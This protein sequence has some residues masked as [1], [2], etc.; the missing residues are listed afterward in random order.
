MGRNRQV[1][2]N[3]CNKHVRNDNL[4]RHL[5]SHNIEHNVTREVDRITSGNI[6]PSVVNSRKMDSCSNF[7]T[8]FRQLTNLQWFLLK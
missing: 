2:C 7:N 5:R 8:T 6:F 3:I 4:P 1:L